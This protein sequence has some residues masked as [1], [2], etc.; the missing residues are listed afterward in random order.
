[1][2]R[3]DFYMTVLKSRFASLPGEVLPRPSIYAKPKTVVPPGQPVTIVCQSPAGAE[4][5][6]LE[7]KSESNEYEDQRKVPQHDSQ[8][9]EAR[10]HITAS[11]ATAGHYFCRYHKGNSWSKHSELLELVVTDEDISTLPSGLC[12]APGSCPQLVHC[13]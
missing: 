12:Q 7:K 1:M 11:K 4:V 9:A 5:F 2:R 13:P 8:E 6:R 10:F 3:G